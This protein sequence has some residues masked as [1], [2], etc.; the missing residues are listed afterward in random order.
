MKNRDTFLCE[1][2]ESYVN[3]NISFVKEEAKKL[4]KADRKMLYK[5]SWKLGERS[6]DAWFF[7]ELI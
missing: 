7:F 2:I 4:T 6:K 5:M 3:G 1:L